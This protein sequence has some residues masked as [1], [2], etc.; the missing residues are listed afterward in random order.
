MEFIDFILTNYPFSNY[1]NYKDSL[2]DKIIDDILVTIFPKYHPDNYNN[3]EDYRVY[4]EIYI[5]LGKMKDDLIK[6]K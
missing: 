6:Y 1:E 3:R 4:N 5:L 2:K